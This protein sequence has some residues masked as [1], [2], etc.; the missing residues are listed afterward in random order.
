MHG[1]VDL[2]GGADDLAVEP[3]CEHELRVDERAE[4]E[5]HCEAT[6]RETEE[7]AHP[8]IDVRVIAA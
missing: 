4:R 6:V 8:A 3:E 7:V 2:E 5:T 1:A